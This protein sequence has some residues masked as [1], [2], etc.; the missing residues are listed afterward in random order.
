QYPQAAG[1]DLLLTDVISFEVRVL[2]PQSVNRVKSNPRL[3][4][5]VDL[6]DSLA[7]ANNLAPLP[8]LRSMNPLFPPPAP[9]TV[10]VPR[11]F[12]T[13]SSVQ[14]DTYNY[15][16]WNDAKPNSPGAVQNTRVP[17][18]LR[19]LAPQN[20]LRVWDLKSQQA[21]QVTIVQEM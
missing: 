19:I 4:A 20:T 18:P 2:L 8:V 17:L 9:Q 13:W 14:D 3:D 21:R 1:A 16:T 6:F 5:F 10:T 7:L 15:S 11:I 12:E